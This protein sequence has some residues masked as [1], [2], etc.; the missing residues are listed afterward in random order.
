MA[1]FRLAGCSISSGQS[2][3][4][5][6][7]HQSVKKGISRPVAVVASTANAQTMLLAAAPERIGRQGILV[8]VH[9]SR[10]RLVFVDGEQRRVVAAKLETPVHRSPSPGSG[11]P[12]RSTRNAGAMSLSRIRHVPA[13]FKFESGWNIPELYSNAEPPDSEMLG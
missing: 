1:S 13:S 4:A 6:L 12:K 7:S 8:T 11:S 9:I 3:L 10:R 2:P 5:V